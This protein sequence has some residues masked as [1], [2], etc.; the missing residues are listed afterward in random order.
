MAAGA[1]CHPAGTHR[2]RECHL[3]DPSSQHPVPWTMTRDHGPLQ[4]CWS[5]G[6]L[7]PSLGVFQL[8]RWMLLCRCKFMCLAA[9]RSSG[10]A[11]WS[12][13]K[14]F[15]QLHDTVPAAGCGEDKSHLVQL[16]GGEHSHTELHL[17]EILP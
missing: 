13:P 15:V 16:M 14:E 1:E 11:R 7:Q 3:R 6:T 9:E 4:V 8:W 5:G 10:W 12:V 17:E 2:A